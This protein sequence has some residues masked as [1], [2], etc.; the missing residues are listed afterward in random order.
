MNE[1]EP[2]AWTVRVPQRDAV[3]VRD[4][5][6]RQARGL[7]EVVRTAPSRDR[8]RERCVFLDL[9]DDRCLFLVETRA[10]PANVAAPGPAEVTFG[11]GTSGPRSRGRTG[12]TQ[13]G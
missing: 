3:S 4:H 7:C 1:G 11:G 2:R 9:K 10:E 12:G 8:G 5:R 13:L 6:S